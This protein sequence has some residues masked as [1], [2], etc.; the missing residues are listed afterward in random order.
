M[1]GIGLLNSA[2]PPGT[3]IYYALAWWQIPCVVSSTTVAVCSWIELDFPAKWAAHR[4][5]VTQTA[6]NTWGWSDAIYGSGTW[7]AGGPFPMP[8]LPTPATSFLGAVQSGTA[9]GTVTG[10]IDAQGNL[11]AGSSLTVSFAGNIQPRFLPT[12]VLD[13][14]AL[15]LTLDGAAVAAGPNTNTTVNIS[16]SISEINN[17]DAALATIALLPGTNVVSNRITA[18][19]GSDH[20][21]SGSFV[22][23]FSTPNYQFD[24]TL[25]GGNFV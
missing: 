25:A 4:L 21:V 8:T 22:G 24:G 18:Q 16:G 2:T 7:S 20:P 19:V 5:T 1:K 14:T 13:H 17:A 15:A 12:A 10:P 11:N 9:T 3:T 23:R 6:T